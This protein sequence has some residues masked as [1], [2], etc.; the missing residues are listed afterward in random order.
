LCV[1]DPFWRGTEFE[2]ETVGGSSG[3]TDFWRVRSFRTSEEGNSK[4]FTV[5]EV[6]VGDGQADEGSGEEELDVSLP[7]FPLNSW[8]ISSCSE[9]AGISL[10]SSCC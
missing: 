7:L 4:V 3:E 1:F 6:F 10:F 9:V 2:W 5:T 8:A